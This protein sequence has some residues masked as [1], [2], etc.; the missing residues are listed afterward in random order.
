MTYML[1]LVALFAPAFA[2][3]GPAAPLPTTAEL[4]NGLTEMRRGLRNVR[5]EVAVSWE[6]DMGPGA[7]PTVYQSAWHELFL[8][9]GAARWRTGE[10]RFEERPSGRPAPLEACVRL[11]SARGDAAALMMSRTEGAEPWYDEPSDTIYHSYEAP[12]IALRFFPKVAHLR[13]GRGWHEPGAEVG[14]LYR[15]AASDPADWIVEGREEKDGRPAVGVRLPSK[16][17]AEDLRAWF[18]DDAYFDL[19]RVEVAALPR[20]TDIDLI[21]PKALPEDVT[22]NV[23]ELS[24]FRPLPD[25]GRYPFA[26]SETAYVSPTEPQGRG[27][28]VARLF[29]KIVPI[30]ELPAE[31]ANFVVL[32]RRWR[33]EAL[34]P[35]EQTAPLWIEA[36][37]GALQQDVDERERRIVGVSPIESWLILTT[38][39]RHALWWTVGPPV[40]L[41]TLAALLWW[42]WRSRP[43][44]RLPPAPE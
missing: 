26:G 30:S 25:G 40:V 18:T 37:P 11:T 31:A 36:P 3:T 32:Q 20:A 10:G 7:A 22:G 13:A 16:N 27:A 21:L 23:I 34:E 19:F 15:F 39:N 44:R 33:V 28:G 35:L 1:A 14:V 2:S 38:G 4:A 17:G 8:S 24:D 9:G 41:V 6:V 43:A 42:W 5:A 29:E 12:E